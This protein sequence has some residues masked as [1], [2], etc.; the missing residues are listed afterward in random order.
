[1][2]PSDISTICLRMSDDGSSQTRMNG[3]RR[4]Q[5]MEGV[6]QLTGN[7]SPLEESALST[8]SPIDQ[9][10]SRTDNESSRNV[11]P[12]ETHGP[13][14]IETRVRG[15][16]E[17]TRLL[18][19]GNESS[20]LSGP[21][22]NTTRSAT[23]K[24]C[25]GFDSRS[26]KAVHEVQLLGFLSW[27]SLKAASAVAITTI[28]KLCSRPRKVR[29]QPVVSVMR[30]Q[31]TVS[32]FFGRATRLATG[33]AWKA[34][35][36]GQPGLASSNLASSAVAGSG[37]GFRRQTVNLFGGGSIPLGHPVTSRRA[38]G[39]NSA[40]VSRC[41]APRCSRFS[42]VSQARRVDRSNAGDC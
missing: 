16:Q 35:E 12:I 26:Y 36:S 23:G 30:D 28:Q 4:T 33:C 39:K 14:D 15:R 13:T 22:N 37:A 40:T 1:M 8:G 20:I 29:E 5:L 19:G 24:C 25:R 3:C 42:A 10:R 6:S 31:T 17:C 18:T 11:I 41:G 7:A 38:V 2:W 21:T 27:S 9:H 32:V 34:F